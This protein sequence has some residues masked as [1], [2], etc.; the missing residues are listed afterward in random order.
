ME[1]E[2]FDFLFDQLCDIMIYLSH[3]VIDLFVFD[4]A[5]WFNRLW[6][7][8][9]DIFRHRL[10]FFLWLTL[11]FGLPSMSRIDNLL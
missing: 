8:T 9:L 6:M 3:L 2:L 5:S 1:R 7:L 11:I 4:C 10:N